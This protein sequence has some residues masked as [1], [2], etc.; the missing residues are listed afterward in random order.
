MRNR[1]R[2][3]AVAGSALGPD[4]YRFLAAQFLSSFGAGV[5]G[6][7]LPWLVID[8]SGSGT[9]AGL[10]FAATI[11][12]YVLAGIPAGVVS[13]RFPGRS[14][15]WCSLAAQS[16]L[17][18]MIPV[19]SLLAGPPLWLLVI[20]AFAIGTTRVFADAAGFSLI[21]ALLGPENFVAGQ[22]LVASA[23]SLA[24]LVG[25]VA[26]GALVATL[27]APKTLAADA[28]CLACA[29]VAIRRIRRV[30]LTAPDAP[31]ISAV[32]RAT[33]GL[34]FIV[35]SPFVRRLTVVGGLSTFTTAG[36]TAL[37]VPLLRTAIGLTPHQVGLAMATSALAGVASGLL[38][39]RLNRRFGAV[40]PFGAAMVIL[41]VAYV[42]LSRA[43]NVAETSAALFLAGAMATVTFATYTGERQRRVPMP[44]QSIVG[45]SA[46]MLMMLCL[47]LGS[48][49]ASL[50]VTFVS[51]RQVFLFIGL[52]CLV[53]AAL[54]WLF[55]VSLSEAEVVEL[56]VVAILEDA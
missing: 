56:P 24:L 33:A 34:A 6:V 29:A 9:V 2:T 26:G 42:G 25:P 17:T 44:L 15:M 22:A 19:W 50:L 12:P 11:A 54:V 52:G 4:G 21:A 18:L 30:S 8:V 35:G 10:V 32:R 53:I 5:T 1:I 14:V 36:A 43:G 40:R 55:L 37:L 45:I 13:D 48:T 27:G 39:G 7:A 46:R 41:G 16:V 23:G 49:A 31:R 3:D 51:V 47:F 28:C 38:V 20:S